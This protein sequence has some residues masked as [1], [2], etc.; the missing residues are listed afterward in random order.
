MENAMP[1]APIR[2]VALDL[3]NTLL[4]SD[5]SVGKRSIEALQA[6]HAQGVEIVLASGR[7]TPAMERTA[8]ML[9][10]DLFLI[11][12]N[13]AA[14]CG[15]MCD[16]RKRL[17][18]LPLDTDVARELY[19]FARE[20]GLQ[21]NYYLDDVIVSENE[22]H[23]RPWIEIY[24]ER[25]GSPYRFVESISDYLHRSPT[26]L[27][28]VMDPKERDAIAEHWKA[29]LG[30][31]AAVVRTDPEY[32]EFLSPGAD[33]GAAV[34]LIAES[35]SIEPA[36]IMAMGDAENDL[37]MLRLAGWPVAVANA[38]PACKA[39]ARAITKNDH[40]NDA[41]AEAVERWV[42]K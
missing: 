17:F 12:Y 4:R 13:G 18:H 30:T 33:K 2:L 38:N 26:K 6:A 10:L 35:L 8:E 22:P 16:G 23:L 29:R 32:L 21:V 37:P 14:V 9:G 7:M 19:A 1:P 15:R 11:S 34:K 36:A 39:L 27:L 42:L 41:V 3:D 20:R 31:R 40:E 25:T 28:M 5:R 24:R